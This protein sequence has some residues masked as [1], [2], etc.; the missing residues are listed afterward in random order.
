MKQFILF[1]LV[2]LPVCSSAQFVETFDGPEIDT[3]N[4]WK[5]DLGKFV[6]GEDG[7]LWL[8]GTKETAE[9]V[10]L[11]LNITY[12]PTMQW[13]F[14]VYMKELPSD[15]NYLRLYLYKESDGTYYYVQIGRDGSKKIR[16]QT[17]GMQELFT[18][19]ESGLT[20]PVYLR[21]K[22]TLE[23]NRVWT[24]YSKGE[25]DADFHLEGTTEAYPVDNPVDEGPLV[26]NIKHTKTR[27]KHFA[28]DNIRVS[29]QI[30]PEDDASEEE[31]PEETDEEENVTDEED[32]T[33]ETE[34]EP[35]Q[36]I[37]EETEEIEE[38]VEEE[39]E[40]E[41]TPKAGDILIN[42][43]MAD[44]KG[45]T[46]LPETEYV[47][48]RNMASTAVT[49]DGWQFSYGGKAKVMTTF[50]IAAGGYAVLHRTGREVV[51]A[52]GAQDVPLD[53]F[54]YNLAN[55][56]KDL[57]LLDAG[58]NVVDEYTYPK[59]TPACSW[60]RGSS[61][62]W[63]LSSDPRGGTPGAANSVGAKD[64]DTD[65]TDKEDTTEEEETTEEDVE[66]VRVEPLEF[67]FNELL[68]E[69]FSGGSEY[70]E[71]YNRSSRKLPLAGLSVAVRKSDGTLNTRYPLSSVT[72]WIEPGD[73]AL[74]TKSLVGVTD[75]Y[76]T[77]SPSAL[78]EVAKLP[79]L[80]NTSSTLVLLRTADGEVID[81]VSYS[82]LW[83]SSSVK[84][85]KG[86]ALERIDTEAA[87]QLAA[88]WTSASSLS[89]Y[90]TPGYRNSQAVS[91]DDDKTTGIES[92]QWDEGQG[93]YTLR[94]MLDQ[95]GYGCR[96]FVFNLSGARV[97]EIARGELLGISGQLTW[98][99]CA[100]S[101]SRLP[102]GVYIFYA[103][104]YH[105]SGTAKRHKQVFLVR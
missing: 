7:W 57:Q 72:T 13:E 40:T 104:L 20:K 65:E 73:Y 41:E 93:C 66:A 44:P 34:E 37:E 43:V 3:A 102:A 5:G 101:G 25:G 62:S 49:L 67:V 85:R 81:E 42:E 97:A 39:E 26:L 50:R 84:D 58:G 29:S 87:T 98:D 60:E 89:G 22:V 75:F 94:Y 11:N 48:L 10:G 53:N 16:L 21:I 45:L 28:I 19:R 91:S 30:T 14:D 77:P 103:E 79:I 27:Y 32:P 36:D 100:L 54:P 12:S 99:G 6:I 46:S 33:E 51:T 95:A 9:T 59:A 31:T 1:L 88:G 35:E 17:N 15:D 90:G 92:P 63:H 74:L 56:G 71:L 83:H 76:A 86:V 96:A 55:D 38:D 24:M 4:P 23:D 2:L 8:N 52:G 105:S 61:G 64:D 68:P 69:P 80:A 70:I 47:E 78:F 82:Y 18:P